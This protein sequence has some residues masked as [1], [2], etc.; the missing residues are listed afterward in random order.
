MSRDCLA[1]TQYMLLFLL[2]YTEAAYSQVHYY[3]T[4]SP[5]I[6][7]PQ[8]PCLTLSQ[9]AADFS[10]YHGNETN[11]SLSFLP[12][13]HSLD[14]ELSLF[15]ADNFIITKDIA[16]SGPGNVFVECVNQL[17][18]F[19]ISMTTFA[20]IKGLHFI[21]CGGNRVSQV[22]QFIVEDTIFQGVE[23]RGT[24]LERNELLTILAALTS[25]S[26]NT[27][28]STFEHYGF[29]PNSS[30]QDI[31][32]YVYLKRN[33]AVGGAL[34][35]V[36]SNISIT[37]S[38]FTHNTAEIGG[39]LFAHNSTLLVIGSTYSY[40]IASFG[41]IIIT[42][43]SSVHIDN[44]TFSKNA[45]EVIGGVMIAY[46]DLFSIS[47]STFTNNRAGIYSGVMNL[48]SVSQI[49]LS[50]IIQLKSVVE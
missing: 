41:G 7:C 1:L 5:N 31:L 36:F 4:P 44:S 47:N 20:V 15:L 19:N 2:V 48:Y 39:A 42:S 6:P 12:G 10:N 21:G 16:N 13:N 28:G 11:M 22:E 8:D 26:T 14:R 37:S 30:N 35:I 38:K 27:H 29:S 25:L 50:V 17:G 34:Y 23:G 24:A 9:F 45:A 43:E 32:N 3:I 49:A 18:R 40:N 46:K 33:S